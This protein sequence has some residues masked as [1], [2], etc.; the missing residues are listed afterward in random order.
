[1]LV[2]GVGASGVDYCPPVC[3]G[4]SLTQQSGDVTVSLTSKTFI[5]IYRVSIIALWEN[6]EIAYTLTYVVLP[7]CTKL[8][9][10][11]TQSQSFV[12]PACD[13]CGGL[14]LTFVTDSVPIMQFLKDRSKSSTL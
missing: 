12:I 3:P 9:I 2:K 6:I 4:I 7:R 1:L 11:G 13:G 8:S 5:S 14:R 10:L